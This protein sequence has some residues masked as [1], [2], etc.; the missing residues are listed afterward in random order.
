M[1]KNKRLLI[2]FLTFALYTE[3]STTIMPRYN[4]LYNNMV[5]NIEKSKSNEQNYRLI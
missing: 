3:A 1:K 4:R 5:E 2:I